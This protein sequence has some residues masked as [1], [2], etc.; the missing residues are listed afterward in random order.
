VIVHD[1]DRRASGKLVAAERA[2]NALIAENAAEGHTVVLDPD[3]EAVAG[4]AG[5]SRKPERAWREFASR[6]SAEMP[7]PLVRAAELAISLAGREEGPLTHLPYR[8]RFEA[9]SAH[10]GAYGSG[11]SSSEV[12]G[13]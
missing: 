12:R 1:S 6:P 9:S 5:H 3:F 11:D 8:G 7:E 4:L 13:P 2:L 10:A